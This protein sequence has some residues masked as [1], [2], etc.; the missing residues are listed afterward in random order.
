MK[1]SGCMGP[2][3]Y[4]GPPS[5]I[6]DRAARA[7]DPEDLRVNA[8]MYPR[9]RVARAATP[10]PHMSRYDPSGPSRPMLPI[11]PSDE[12][13][14]TYKLRELLIIT[15]QSYDQRLCASKKASCARR[16]LSS[17]Y[18]PQ[19]FSGIYVSSDGRISGGWVF[20]ANPKRI[21]LASDRKD[22]FSPETSGNSGWNEVIFE[23]IY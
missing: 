17:E 12:W 13:R 20:L 3:D 7:I 23:R 5:T 8:D 18:V 6:A 11:L 2:A 15:S 10:P 9:F 16:I 19:W 22:Y 1:L 4:L 21:L 14:V